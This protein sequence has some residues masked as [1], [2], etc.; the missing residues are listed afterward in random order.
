[1]VGSPELLRIRVG[2]HPEDT[3]VSLWVVLDL[4]DGSMVVRDTTV[5][6][7]TIRVSIG[8]R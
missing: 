8:R 3:P 4:A 5:S 2:H 6:G 7:D 1:M